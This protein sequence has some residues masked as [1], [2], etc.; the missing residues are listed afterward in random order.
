MALV[1]LLET[2][3]VWKMRNLGLGVSRHKLKQSPPSYR[4]AVV[5]GFWPLDC[6]LPPVYCC[7]QCSKA[8][9]P[10]H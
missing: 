3:I 4:N 10:Y 9:T 6:L 2:P 1:C 7:Q 5:V 8:G